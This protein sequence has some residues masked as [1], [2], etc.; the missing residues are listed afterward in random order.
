V[1][2]GS[3]HPK[4]QIQWLSAP[5]R[6]QKVIDHLRDHPADCR[7]LFS[8]DA[9]RPQNDGDRPSGK[10]KLSVCA[11]IVRYVF[12]NDAEYVKHYADEPDKFRDST[13]SHINGYIVLTLFL[14][15]Y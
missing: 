11:V 6:T 12:Q 8:S 1:G 2:G 14:K 15:V 9:K 4:F 13:N 3:D 7:I 5:F 10:D